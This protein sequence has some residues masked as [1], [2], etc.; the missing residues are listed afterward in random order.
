MRIIYYPSSLENWGRAG[1][2]S[3]YAYNLRRMSAVPAGLGSTHV[4]EVFQEGGKNH[5]PDK[6]NMCPALNPV[7]EASSST[8]R[9]TSS[10]LLCICRATTYHNDPREP[11]NRKSPEHPMARHDNNNADGRRQS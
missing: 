2:L 11:G 10:I 8:P 5:R 7:R 4:V 6:R 9:R 1:L 3:T